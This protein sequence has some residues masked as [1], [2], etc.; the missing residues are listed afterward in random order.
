[1][2]EAV[3]LGHHSGIVLREGD[4]DDFMTCFRELAGLCE[5]TDVMYER[6]IAAELV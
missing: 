6:D 1:M 3:H 2:D 4:D 5:N